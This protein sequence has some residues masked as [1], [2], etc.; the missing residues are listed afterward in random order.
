MRDLL[1]ICGTVSLIFSDQ[2]LLA[3]NLSQAARSLGLDDAG[4]DELLG[5]GLAFGLFVVGGLAAVLVGAAADGWI[6]RVDLLA[7]IL[8]V[9][10][11]GC[12]GSALSP[13]Y[14]PL[15][16]SRAVTG[17]GLGGALPL[18]FSLVGDL[19]P[20][21]DRTRV[22]GRIG[23]AMSFGTSAGQLLAG[24]L[25]PR[26]GW[27]S[28]FAITGSLMVVYAMLVQRALKEPLRTTHDA[29]SLRASARGWVAMCKVP[30]VWLV[31]LQGLPGCV[32]WG[33]IGTFLPDYLH[34]NCGYAHTRC[35][36]HAPRA[37]QTRGWARA[38]PS[39]CAQVQR[40]RGIGRDGVLLFWRACG[41]HH[42]G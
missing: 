12:L 34:I 33:V 1:I 8:G 9:G 28:P 35:P 41:H 26:F 2:N 17:V 5:G 20:P 42:W 24:V 3:P 10:G 39:A 22:S 7:L 13:A 31:F 21:A 15:F 6:R 38:E 4:R 37:F 30:T 19:Y 29:P 32:P 40:E 14:L 18:T 36:A 27:R 23:I 16:I 11:L 25:G